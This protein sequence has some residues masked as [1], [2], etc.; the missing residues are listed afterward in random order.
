MHAQEMEP[1]MQQLQA[2]MRTMDHCMQDAMI[3]GGDF[4]RSFAQMMIAHHEGAM[5]MPR[6]AL[7][8]VQ[9]PRMYQMLDKT[10]E[11]NQ[12]DAQDLRAWLT[13]AASQ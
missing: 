2:S 13:L 1:A 6:I 5:E 9:N 11:E 8:R 12:H 7:Q 4:A 3:G 10:I